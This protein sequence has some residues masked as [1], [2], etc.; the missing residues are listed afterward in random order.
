MC[1]DVF[2]VIRYKTRQESKLATQVDSI[3]H[4]TYSY[5]VQRRLEDLLGLIHFSL[6]T[7]QRRRESNEDERQGCYLEIATQQR[8]KK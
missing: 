6:A 4:H 2:T 1:D 7:R 8:Q 5:D 3:T